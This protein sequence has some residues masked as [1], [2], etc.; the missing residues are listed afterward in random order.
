M[1]REDIDSKHM[2]PAFV[3]ITNVA[4]ERYGWMEFHREPFFIRSNGG[5]RRIITLASRP[6]PSQDDVILFAC[7]MRVQTTELRLITLKL[8]AKVGV[9]EEVLCLFQAYDGIYIGEGRKED[10]FRYEERFL[11]Y[12]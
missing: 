6:L 10:F 4:F 1:K 9:T 3:A 5:D 7:T 12:N 2:N 11:E 8:T